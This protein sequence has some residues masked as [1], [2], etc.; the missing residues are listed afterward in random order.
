MS[1]FLA[2]RL[3][4]LEVY[5][6][7]EQPQDQPYIKLNTNESPFPPSPGVLRAVS[8]KEVSRL[9]LYSDPEAKNLVAALAKHYAVEPENIFVSNGSD[10]I[11]NFCFR[12][13]C[14]DG[15]VFPE[16]TY[17]FYEV[18]AN[19]HG[20]PFERIPM[21]PDFS[22]DPA[23]YRNT[24]RAVV[25]A[26]PNAQ[27]GL[28]LSR[29]VLEEIVRS[30]PDHVVVVDEAYVDFGGESCAALTGRYEN[31]LAVMTFSKSRCLAGARLGFAIG[32]KDLISDLKRLQYSTNPYNLN[33]LTQLAGIAALEDQDYYDECDRRIQATRHRTRQ[34]L[35]N[36]GFT[37]TDSRSNFLLASSPRIP[38]GELYRKLKERGI[39]IRH[40]S[41]PKIEN[42]NRIT[43]GSDKQMDALLAAIEALLKNQGGPFH[44]HE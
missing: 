1:R 5:T 42:W 25:I 12:A 4:S 8:Q 10:D 36:L 41:D 44:A 3:S 11:L 38:G 9:N 17:G 21:N 19:L 40:F 29:A 37:V 34:A 2:P 30:N 18:Y 33:R 13:F 32:P 7:G 31:L 28:A 27:T 15:V 22:I 20:V 6:P 14:E 26:N 35:M 23:A 39:L 24:G 16:I 43:I